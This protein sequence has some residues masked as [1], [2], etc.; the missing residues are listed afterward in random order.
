M[1][2]L[3][4]TGS[5][6][7]ATSRTDLYAELEKTRIDRQPAIAQLLM[8]YNIAEEQEKLN[9]TTLCGALMMLFL[10]PTVSYLGYRLTTI[11]EVASKILHDDIDLALRGCPA[12]VRKKKSKKK[13]DQTRLIQRSF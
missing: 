1:G 7:I 5:S 11:D 8:A 9:W 13:S 10:F 4:S 3:F 6:T 2:N 12:P